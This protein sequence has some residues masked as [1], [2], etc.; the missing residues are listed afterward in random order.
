[1][2]K[3]GGSQIIQSVT[4]E[5]SLKMGFFRGFIHYEKKRKH[6]ETANQR[7]EIKGRAQA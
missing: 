2:V 7:Q 3:D 1:L 5:F 6:Q 4:S